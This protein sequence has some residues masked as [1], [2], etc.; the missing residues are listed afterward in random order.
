MQGRKKKLFIIPLILLFSG[1]T[2]CEKNSKD[3][4]LAEKWNTPAKKWT[5]EQLASLTSGE[6]LYEKYCAA[7]HLKNGQGNMTN[8]FPPLK[9]SAIAKGPAR[10]HIKI[11]LHGKQGSTMPAFANLPDADLA[12]IIIYERN[13][14]GNNVGDWVDKQAIQALRRTKVK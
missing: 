10:Q 4:N 1:L 9:G 3:I 7:C 12:K 11:V 8:G 6:R 14:W 13:A 2:S 5:K